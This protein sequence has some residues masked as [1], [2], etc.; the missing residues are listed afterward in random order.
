M[1]N[2]LIERE[3]LCDLSHLWREMYGK[4]NMET[5]ISICK[6]RQAV[7]ICCVTQGTQTRALGQPRGVE[8]RFKREGTHVYPGLIHGN[9]WQ[10][11][12]QFC[13]AIILQL[14]KKNPDS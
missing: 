4:S 10:Q 5:C 12:T 14:K 8:K 11:P 7:G 2:E 1:V 9:V 3:I 6:M 13:K